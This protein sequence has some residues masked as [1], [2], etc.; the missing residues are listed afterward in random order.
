MKRIVECI[1]NFSEGRKKEIV[2][3]IV[4][5]IT[6][7][8]GAL[9][10]D[11]EMDADHNRAVVTFAGEPEAVEEAAFRGAEVASRLIDLDEHRG[12]HPRIGATDVIP[13]VP[14]AG[15]T[16]EECVQMARRL[17][18]RIGRE[19]EIPVYLYEKAAT[20]PE[21][22]NLAHIRHGEYEGLKE[23]I[24]TDP[25]REPDFGPRKLGKA[26]ATAV[27]AR[28]PLVAY[29]IYLS[30]HDIEIA[31]A[32]AKAVRH[33]SGGLTC[34]KAL[35]MEIKQ[36]GLVQVSMNMTDYRR[37]PLHRA[38]ELVRREAERYGV[39]VISS[40]IVGLAPEGALLEAAEFYLQLEGF[41]PHQVLE[42]R[43]TQ[44]LEESPPA[45]KPTEGMEAFLEAVA[46]A[47]P[48]P[49]GGSV[50][51]LAGALAAALSSMVCQLTL[52]KEEFA[53]VE[54]QMRAA[55]EEA[56]GLKK[57]LQALIEE[58]A[59]A[60]HAILE[61]YR[62]P[63]K[64]KEEKE[65]RGWAIQAALRGAASVPLTVAERGVR[66]L[67]LIQT[68]AQS[69][70]PEAASDAGTAAYMALAAV[71]G[72]ALNVRTNAY[73]LDDTELTKAFEEQISILEDRAQGLAEEIKDLVVV[74]MKG[75]SAS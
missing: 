55:L 70:N 22:E 14:I 74:R 23:T 4:A 28:E 59:S 45:M 46:S 39:S 27:G 3:Q 24:A 47:S 69:G 66:V 26:G 10:L 12:E 20:H 35:G 62:L 68:V 63:R 11:T 51:A 6:G 40:E 75:S 41:D 42:H 54:P 16:M 57:E 72:A 61:A 17:G 43:L 1:P 32:I 19:L 48:A 56:Q 36:R 34:V 33:S 67:E 73:S 37:T 13:F 9:L 50:A 58:D 38:L 64:S 5:A 7:V 15:V 49:G 31:Q 52:G 25:E 60:F 21:R 2:D 53:S 65:R 8:Q 44:K 18:E 71:M 30:S 29:N